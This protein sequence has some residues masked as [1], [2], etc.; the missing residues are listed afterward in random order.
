M[1][2]KLTVAIMAMSRK[3]VLQCNF[4]FRSKLFEITSAG[5][6]DGKAPISL[7]SFSNFHCRIGPVSVDPVLEKTFLEHALLL[8]D[9]EFPISRKRFLQL[10]DICFIADAK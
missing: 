8:A 7:E 10:C 3:Q 9:R 2:F 1:R 5:V 4:P 6:A